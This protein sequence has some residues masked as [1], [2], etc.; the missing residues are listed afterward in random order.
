MLPGYLTTELCSLRS[1][2]DHLAFSVL[3]EMDL[4]ANI[5]D[6][7]FCKSVIRSV[8]SLTY[9]QAQS[10]LDS[11]CPADEVNNSVNLLNRMARVLRAK[12][13]ENGALTLASPEVRFKLDQETSD[14]TDVSLYALKEANALV[15]EFMLLA[16]ITVAKKI[17]KHYPTLAILRRHQP[18]SREQFAPLLAAANVAGVSLDI[19]N[20]K[21]LAD[22]L[23]ATVRMDDPYFN[24]LMRI[25]STRCMMPAQYFCSGEIPKDQWHHYGLA[26]PVYTHFTSPIRRY[27]DVLVHRLLAAALGV[28]PLPHAN[29]QRGK[30]QE[31]C[32][33]MNRRH[34]AAQY[35]QRA[36]VQLYTNIF[37]T[38]KVVVE[39]GYIININSSGISV[40]VPKYGIEEF[41]DSTKYSQ[42]YQLKSCSFDEEKLSVK[43]INNDGTERLLRILDRICVEIKVVLDEYGEKQLQLMIIH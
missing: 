41:I 20:S 18:P 3:W 21:K 9:D 26:T 14:P 1:N 12:R 8:A 25:L 10:M 24:K 2:E 15:E 5:Y 34:R 40:I 42:R 17:L 30:Q 13:I 32:A 29:A 7:Q 4:D 37:F 6:V 28:I 35:A 16:N 43:S 23:D 22:S 39:D 33:H 19:G 27:A 38:D 36:S 31:L 11:P